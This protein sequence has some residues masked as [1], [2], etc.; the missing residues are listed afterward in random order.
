MNKTRLLALALALMLVLSGAALA[1]GN[2]NEINWIE[3]SSDASERLAVMLA[4]DMPDA[5][6]GLLN[7]SLMV[8][9]SS[10]FL[11][12]DDLIETYCPTSTPTMRLRSTAG[13]ST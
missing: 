6:M 9:N 7:D 1:D 13:A 4:G 12:L 10:M 5:F 11:V 2:F 8:Q 3:I